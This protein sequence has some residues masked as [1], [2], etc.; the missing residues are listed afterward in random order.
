MS[1]GIYVCAWDG[2]IDMKSQLT[3]RTDIHSHGPVRMRLFYFFK[4][5]ANIY[6]E[7]VCMYKLCLTRT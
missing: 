2:V 4:E 6:Y 7:H 1:E 5:Q 3:P